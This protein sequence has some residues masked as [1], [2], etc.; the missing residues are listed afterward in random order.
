MVVCGGSCGGVGVGGRGCVVRWISVFFSEMRSNQLGGNDVMKRPF[1][2][3][4]PTDLTL[5]LN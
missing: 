3:C 4:C 2:M 1:H 5:T